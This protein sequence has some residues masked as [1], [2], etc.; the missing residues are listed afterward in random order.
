MNTATT[1]ALCVEYTLK[2][3]MLQRDQR[4]HHLKL[5]YPSVIYM[6]CSWTLYKILVT[7]IY[8]LVYSFMYAF[9]SMW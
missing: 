5:L 2:I 1:E 6:E 9:I 3:G 8:S 4:H 7:S